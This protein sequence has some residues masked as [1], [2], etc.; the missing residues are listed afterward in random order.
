MEVLLSP[1]PVVP[2]GVPHSPVP[3]LPAPR[4]VMPLLALTGAFLSCCSTLLACPKMGLSLGSAD[5]G[6]I[7]P[8]LVVVNEV[9][10]TICVCIASGSV[11]SHLF[12]TACLAHKASPAVCRKCAMNNILTDTQ[13]RK[14][15]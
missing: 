5:Y 9:M 8:P 11:G 4:S 15:R 14:C 1:P 3:A 10:G 6:H 7:G 13:V 2:F 12:V